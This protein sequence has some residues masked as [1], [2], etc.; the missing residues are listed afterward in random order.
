M[1]MMAMKSSRWAVHLIRKR[2][3]HLG[4]VT[5]PDE[6]TAVLEAIKHFEIDQPRQNRIEVSR[7]GDAQ[8]DAAE[9]KTKPRKKSPRR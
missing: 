6:Q 8:D 5:A 3:K 2:A 4:T 1:R 9:P 7:I